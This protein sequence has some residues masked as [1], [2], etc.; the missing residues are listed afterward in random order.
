[1]RNCKAFGLIIALSHVIILNLEAGFLVF[2]ELF[3]LLL[4][5]EVDE[6]IHRRGFV[7]GGTVRE[8]KKKLSIDVDVHDLGRDRDFIAIE[9]RFFV[10]VIEIPL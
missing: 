10:R 8:I 5:N 1:M 2:F 9:K 3:G 4:R 7:R 6:M